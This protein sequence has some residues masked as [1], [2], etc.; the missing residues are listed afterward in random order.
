[1]TTYTG[2]QTVKGGYYLNTRDWKLEV[3]NAPAGVLPGDE[4]AP[5]RRVPAPAMLVVAPLMGMV[6]VM[7]IPFFGLAVLGEQAW[8][9][10]GPHLHAARKPS[11]PAA[12]LKTAAGPRR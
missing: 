3:V 9:K 4:G 12:T 7:L 11:V 5:Y 2:T 6:F 1:M 10:V 8:H